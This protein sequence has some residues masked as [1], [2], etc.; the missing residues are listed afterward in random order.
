MSWARTD[1]AALATS[2]ARLRVGMITLS[3]A[4]TPW[5]PRSASDRPHDS[6]RLVQPLPRS[7]SRMAANRSRAR[8]KGLARIDATCRRACSSSAPRATCSRRRRVTRSA[9]G[10]GWAGSGLLGP[11]RTGRA[12]CVEEPRVDRGEIGVH[13]KAVR[14]FAG[15]HPLAVAVLPR[16][17]TRE[18]VVVTR[19]VEDDDPQSRHWPGGRDRCRTGATPGRDRCAGAS[20]AAPPSRARRARRRRREGPDA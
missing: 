11:G 18:R 14:P 20:G 12:R 17:T 2:P 19:C 8:Q 3:I 5:S 16:D 7:R 6:V 1:A 10:A 9:M 13:R 15:Q 4:G